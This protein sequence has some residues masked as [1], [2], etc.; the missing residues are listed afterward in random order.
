[1]LCVGPPLLARAFRMARRGSSVQNVAYGIAGNIGVLGVTHKRVIDDR[2]AIGPHVRVGCGS[3]WR[4]CFSKRYRS[5]GFGSSSNR[6]QC[7]PRTSAVSG[8]RAVLDHEIA[9][10]VLDAA[11]AV[12]GV[13]GGVARDGGIHDRGNGYRGLTT[14][15]P[16]GRR[17]R[18]RIAR[19][20]EPCCSVPRSRSC[21]CWRFRSCR[22]DRHRRRRC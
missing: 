7:R 1:M 11:A 10:G 5:S 15:A 19:R 22:K 21:S 6:T 12:H 8:N 13:D 4:S 16:V 9:V 17:C 2:R 20:S 3:L 18:L 14:A